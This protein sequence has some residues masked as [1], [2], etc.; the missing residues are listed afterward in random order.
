MRSTLIRSRIGADGILH[1]DVPSDF[2]E[3]ELEVIVIVQPTT[4]SAAGREEDVAW[5]LDFFESVVG[6]WQGEPLTREWEG[7]YETRDRM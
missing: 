6:K 1:L 2:V 4:Q 7:Q 3:T 5:S